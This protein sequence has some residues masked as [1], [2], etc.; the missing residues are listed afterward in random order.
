MQSMEYPDAYS[1]HPLRILHFIPHY[2]PAW[3]YGGPVQ[4]VPTL[5]KAL[6]SEG[7]EVHVYTTNVDGTDFLQVPT[8]HPVLVD[9]V[10]VHY[11]PGVNKFG[12]VISPAL[13][14]KVRR[15]ICYFDVVHASSMWQSLLW[16]V[17][18]SAQQYSR[19]VVISPRGGL[20]SYAWK[21]R[22]LKHR[23]YWA[24]IERQNYM[25][26]T[27][28][29]FTAEM[30]RLQATAI[31]LRQRSFVVPNGINLDIHR[32][33]ETAGFAFRRQLGISDDAFVILYLGRLHPIKG[34]DLLI[35]AFSTVAHESIMTFCRPLYLVIAGGDEGGYRS[36]LENLVMEMQLVSSV[37][38]VGAVDGK[39]RAA[40]YSSSDVFVL[41]SHNENFG[42]SAV[43]AMAH[44]LPLLVS[45]QVCIAPELA[46]DGA[47]IVV[48][49][50]ERDWASALRSVLSNSDLRRDLAEKGLLSARTRFDARS[51]ARQMATEYRNTI[52][53]HGKML[54]RQSKIHAC[55]YS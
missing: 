27:S 44:R 47:A 39:G 22:R 30:E 49:L 52:T 1:Q 31:G 7:H 36:I 28:L 53:E 16:P 29:H 35:S 5:C 37:F 19:P 11:L 8:D 13:V 6:V 55:C 43:E 32:R 4:S 51:V 38:F 54:H 41:P 3:R 9:G 17:T 12:M 26:A 15:E 21:I 18:R 45:D 10:A 48:P 20:N 33:D 50:T 24:F 2:A 46:A 23:L 34:L 42:M 14:H 25:R 40:A